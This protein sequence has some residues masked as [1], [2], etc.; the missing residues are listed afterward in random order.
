VLL[1]PPT[2]G[3][4]IKKV[5]E[6]RCRIRRRGQERL[7]SV[8]KDDDDICGDDGGNDDDDVCGNGDGNDDAA[9]TT[10]TTTCTDKI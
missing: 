3:R 7:G 1:A 8:A 9:N 6:R 2:T 10:T 4:R 5:G